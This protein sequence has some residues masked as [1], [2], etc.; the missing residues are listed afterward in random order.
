VG[1][2]LF[3]IAFSRLSH[4]IGD[5]GEAKNMNARGF[6]KSIKRSRLHFDRK[7]ALRFGCFDRRQRF[8]ER[9]VSCP[10]GA[11][12]RMQTLSL[13]RGESRRRESGVRFGILRR[14]GVVIARSF[15]AQSTLNEDEIWG[16]S[17]R[18]DLAGGGETEQQSAAAGEQ[19][20]RDQNGEGRTYSAADDTGG[21]TRERERIQPGVIAGPGLARLRVAG[22]PDVADDIAIGVEDADRGY[23]GRRKALLPPRFAQQRRRP[24]DRR[25]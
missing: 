1:F 10:T 14:S 11:C 8:S 22:S 19:L 17:G 25:R 2:A 3:K 24:E 16:G 13:N 7:H 15:V 12:D 5:M 18:R 6:G 21:L 20:F 23:I 4:G 9:R